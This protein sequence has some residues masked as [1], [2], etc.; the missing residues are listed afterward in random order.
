VQTNVDTK[1]SERGHFVHW[2]VREPKYFSAQD[3]NDLFPVTVM[4]LLF[5]R[6]GIHICSWVVNVAAHVTFFLYGVH[7]WLPKDHA[8][9]FERDQIVPNRGYV[10]TQRKRIKRVVSQKGTRR[11]ADEMPP[12]LWP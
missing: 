4:Q 8:F 5:G 3:W 7:S 9:D 6:W 10:V 11:P 12:L 2:L 1:P